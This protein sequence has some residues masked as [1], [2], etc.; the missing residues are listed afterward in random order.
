MARGID[1]IALDMG[2]DGWQPDQAAPAYTAARHHLMARNFTPDTA[3]FYQPSGTA[4]PSASASFSTVSFSAS[5]SGYFPTAS[6]SFVAPT[7]SAS[8][9]VTSASGDDDCDETNS[10]EPDY[11][12]TSTAS[13]GTSRDTGSD[14]DE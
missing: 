13:V 8:A 14:D 11:T 12:A 3:S 9:G 7:V 4:Y 10:A 6:G 1:A 5:V 2:F